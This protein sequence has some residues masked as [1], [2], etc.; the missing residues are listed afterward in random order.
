MSDGLT[1]RELWLKVEQ[2]YDCAIRALY[3]TIR[4]LESDLRYTVTTPF[5]WGVE[6]AGI[7]ER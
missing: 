5:A 7:F 2:R 1:H 3:V 4:Q 6:A